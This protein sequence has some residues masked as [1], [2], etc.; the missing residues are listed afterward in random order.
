MPR[1]IRSF[2]RRSPSLPTDWIQAIEVGR[3]CLREGAQDRWA[4][5][6]HLVNTP[7]VNLVIRVDESVAEC[8]RGRHG[9]RHL[10][11]N[12]ACM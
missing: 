4:G 9:A 3:D 2:S 5:A 10:D 6:K 1:R 7:I 11:R 12:D 8:R